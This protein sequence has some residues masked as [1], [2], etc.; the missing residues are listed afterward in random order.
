M[1]ISDNAKT[2]KAASK[3]LSKIKRS[4]KIQ[5]HLANKGV[6]WRFNVEKA[7]HGG[8]GVLTYKLHRAGYAI[9]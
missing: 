4:S 8:L 6:S 1:L 5:Q 2:F 7:W 9:V 3:E